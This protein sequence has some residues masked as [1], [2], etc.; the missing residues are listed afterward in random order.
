MSFR[1]ET[2][3][4]TKPVM[5]TG[6]KYD[7]LSLHQPGYAAFVDRPRNLRGL[8]QKML[9][10]CFYKVQH[11]IGDC[12]GSSSFILSGFHLNLSG[13]QDCQ[14]KGL[15]INSLYCVPE[16][17]YHFCT[18]FL[19]MTSFVGLFNCKGAGEWGLPVCLGRRKQWC[20]CAL[21]N[22]TAHRRLACGQSGIQAVVRN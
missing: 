22:S 19:A 4:E 15:E 13:F 5:G 7:V 10:S 18:H 14:G 20:R 3:V 16:E 2:E 17:T 6:L 9:I 11:G 1:V 12:L 8:R 21:H